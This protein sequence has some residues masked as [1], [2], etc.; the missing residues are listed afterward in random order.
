MKLLDKHLMVL[1][2]LQSNSQISLDELGDRVAMSQSTLWRRIQELESAKIIQ[3][4]VALI[5]IDAM[6]LSVTAMVF[7][8]LQSHDISH[9]QKFE[10]LVAETAH[11]MQCYSITGP[12]DYILLVRAKDMKDFE[13]LLM[14][15]ILAHPS[16]ASAQTSISL[17]TH[18]N[19]TELPI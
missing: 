19:T 6:G 13:S 18:K 9:R 15:T 11:V 3:K 7:V 16:V 4:R 14:N 2:E 17:R 5:D 12:H 8:N 1:R 10:S